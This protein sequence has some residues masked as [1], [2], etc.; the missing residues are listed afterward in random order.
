MQEHVTHNSYL[1]VTNT[2]VGGE[3]FQISK[4][5]VWTEDHKPIST[6]G[7]SSTTRAQE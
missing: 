7:S 2:Y 3:T 6:D 5:D 4:C 1:V